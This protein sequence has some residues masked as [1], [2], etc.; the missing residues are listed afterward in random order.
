MVSANSRLV[1]FQT[2]LDMAK[3]YPLFGVGFGNYNQQNLLTQ[4]L[5]PEAA[6]AYGA[7]VLHNSY[8]QILVDSGIPALVLF[9]SLLLTAIVLLELSYRRL[10]ITNPQLTAYPLGI[11]AGLIV[12]AVGSAGL[13]RESFDFYYML[14]VCAAVWVELEPRLVRAGVSSGTVDAAPVPEAPVLAPVTAYSGR[15]FLRPG[16]GKR[17]SPRLTQRP[18]LRGALL[19]PSYRPDRSRE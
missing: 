17:L 2:A 4:Y 13:S 11:Q 6:L 1:L 5:P 9:V 12:Y 19:S 8:A 7:K 3:D 15:E 16:N 18:P 14:L 10:R